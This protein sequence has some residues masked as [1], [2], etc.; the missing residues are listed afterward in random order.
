MSLSW[1]T[2]VCSHAAK[3][4]EFS[5]TYAYKSRLHR[6]SILAANFRGIHFILCFSTFRVAYFGT[7]E[8]TPLPSLHHRL[9]GFNTTDPLIVT[10]GLNLISN[11]LVT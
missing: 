4:L 11:P 3:T 10:S 2:C 6:F 8:S 5:A 1:V 7:F 9:V